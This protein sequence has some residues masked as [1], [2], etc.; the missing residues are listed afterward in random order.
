MFTTCRI[1]VIDGLNNL[2]PATLLEREL[3]IGR[4]WDRT[5]RLASQV[6]IK[7]D[8]TIKRLDWSN[9]DVTNLQK[10]VINGDASEERSLVH[11]AEKIIIFW[12]LQKN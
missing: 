8:V 3:S 5:V 4:N 2:S 9:A 1:R 7:G 11:N 10:E 12:D 6:K